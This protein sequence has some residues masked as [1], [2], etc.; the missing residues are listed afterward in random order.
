MCNI[1]E[2]VINYLTQ[3]VHLDKGGMTFSLAYSKEVET[4]LTVS[5]KNVN[6]QSRPLQNN[7]PFTQNN[8]N[9]QVF[10]IV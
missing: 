2:N 9:F 7:Y 8:A 6:F 5:I 3:V 1:C 10:C 4:L